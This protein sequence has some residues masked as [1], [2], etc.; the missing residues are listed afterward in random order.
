MKGLL[1]VNSFLKNAKF[2]QLYDFL[3]AAFTEQNVLLEVRSSD[4]LF[5]PVGKK[6]N[7]EW[8]FVLFWDKD[9]R[10]ARAFEE[11]GMRVFNSSRAI[12][13]CD[14]KALTAECLQRSGLAI[15]K[16]LIAPKTYANIGYSNSRFLLRAEEFLSY[17]MVLKQRFGSFGAQVYLAENR[18]QAEEILERDSSAG[19][20]CRKLR[21]G[22]AH[23]CGRKR[24]QGCDAPVQQ[25][26]FSFQYYKRRKDG[27]LF[28]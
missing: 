17:P 14:D 22:P 19:I 13:L 18:K 12:E 10:L 28:S 4:E 15:P 24:G 3:S 6:L 7:R 26:G 11:S 1:V 16:T 8:D 23:Q 27:N 9:L 25:L 21:K 5:L 20:H 2:G